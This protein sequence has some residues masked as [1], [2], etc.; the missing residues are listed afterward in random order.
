MNPQQQATLD[1]VLAALQTELGGLLH[2]C[3]VY[4]S[5]VR[6]NLVE[7][8]S[9]LNLL[10]ILTESTTTAHAAIARA[11]AHQPLIDPFILARPGLER[12]VRAFATKFASIQ[13][14]YQRLCGEDILAGLSFDTQQEKFL[15]EQAMRNLRLRLVYSFVTRQQ[16]QAYDRFVVNN[17]TG[18]MVQMSEA[19]RLE[20][21]TVP[22][23]FEA[24]IPLLETAFQIQGQT[25]RDLVALKKQ[26]GRFSE[27]E[28]VAWH[29]K[30]FPLVDAVVGW[31]ETH[32]QN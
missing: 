1:Q 26:P 23:A 9:D 27:A 32:W 17:I 15:C 16:H 30:I 28:A 6:G 12:S 25:L 20:G 5:A 24:R 29:D 19:L 10:I 8:V 3:Y 31:M 7:G 2:S 22:T 21:T 14:N 4:G 11:L 13:R 18:L